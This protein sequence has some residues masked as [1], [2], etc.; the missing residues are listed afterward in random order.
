MLRRLGPWAGLTALAA[1]ILPPLPAQAE[2]AAQFDAATGHVIVSGLAPDAIAAALAEPDR[3]R[4]QLA[5]SASVSVRGMLV[6]LSQLDGALQITPR[7]A[8]RSGTDY[9]LALDL[10]DSDFETVLALPAAEAEAPHLAGFAPSQAVIP[11]NT[12]RLYLT[13]SRPMARGQLRQAVTLLRADGS[14]VPSPFLTLNAELWDS[15]QTRVTLL[16]DPGRIKQGVGPNSEAGSPLEPGQQYRLVVSQ[17][18]TSADGDPLGADATLVLRAGPA[19]RRAIAVQDW[20]VL[21]PPA[22]SLA[23]LTISFDRIMDSGA[24]RRLLVLRAPDG[25]R[26]RGQVTTDG[27]G[28]SLTPEQSWQPGRYTLVVDPEL[29]DVSGN[30]IGAPFDARPGTIGI[31]THPVTLTIDIPS[32]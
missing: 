8:L 26:V 20:H 19:E 32:S 4:L 11:A 5:G 23:P 27:G 7:F 16:L 14:A 2:I 24:V 28:W 9:A 22:R 31:E 1:L 18:M 25:G 15:G 13:F 6:S 21:A 17:G 30:T 12:L 10:P 3:L 29:E